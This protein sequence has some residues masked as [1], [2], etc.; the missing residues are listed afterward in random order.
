MSTRTP[1]GGV[2]SNR[3]RVCWSVRKELDSARCR[4]EPAGGVRNPREPMRADGKRRYGD[5][6]R[7]REKDKRGESELGRHRVVGDRTAERVMCVKR[8][9]SPEG[10]AD[11]R[12]STEPS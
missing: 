7:T 1:E 6:L 3:R 2:G 9:S 11:P 10:K 4:G 5:K 12:E 8:G